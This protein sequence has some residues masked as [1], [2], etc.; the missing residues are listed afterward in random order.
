VL[1]IRRQGFLLLGA[2][3]WIQQ[4]ASPEPYSL[5]EIN[6]AD[7]SGVSLRWQDFGS[8]AAARAALKRRRTT[9]RQL[10]SDAAPSP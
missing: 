2:V 7:P 4:A 3:L 5:V 9:S 10:S 6:L 8:V 1:S